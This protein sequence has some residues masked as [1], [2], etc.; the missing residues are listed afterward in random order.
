M[1]SLNQQWPYKVNT[2]L[3]LGKYQSRGIRD[4]TLTKQTQAGVG[5]DFLNVNNWAERADCPTSPTFL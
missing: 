1:E 4:K 3:V 5:S 2:I